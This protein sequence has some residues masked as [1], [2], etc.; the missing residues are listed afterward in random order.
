MSRSK[1]VTTK[2][3]ASNNSQSINVVVTF[4]PCRKN[5]KHGAA[6]NILQIWA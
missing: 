6:A 2:H 5:P 3:Q 4:R 1:Q